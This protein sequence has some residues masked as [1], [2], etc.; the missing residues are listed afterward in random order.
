M[1]TKTI[2]YIAAGVALLLLVKKAR[3]DKPGPAAEVPAVQ[4]TAG[5]MPG[6]WWNFGGA[7]SK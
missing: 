4:A 6:D 5:A 1:N 3:A 7:W 2:L